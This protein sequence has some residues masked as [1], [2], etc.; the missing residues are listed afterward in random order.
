MQA[1][2]YCV[3]LSDSLQSGVEDA[4]PPSSRPVHVGRR[5]LG[6]RG[7]GLTSD[8]CVGFSV[9]GVVEEITVAR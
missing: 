6:G 7:G 3:S 4:A 8:I 9:D 5:L 2:R 1:A